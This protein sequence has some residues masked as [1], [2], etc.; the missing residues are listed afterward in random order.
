MTASRSPSA[1]VKCTW[2]LLQGKANEKL[3]LNAREAWWDNLDNVTADNE[4]Q[5]TFHLKRPQPSFIAFL[6]SGFTPV[7]PCHVPAAQMRQHPIGTGPFKFVEFKP[8][9]SIKVTKN[10]DYWKKGLALSR[11]D[12]MD[13]H[14]EPLDPDARLRRRQVRH[15][16]SL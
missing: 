12:R 4:Y 3:R 11:R 15:D 14:S 5:A 13:D 9:Q 6:A 10:P 7:Y 2:D 8:N 16:L 1:D